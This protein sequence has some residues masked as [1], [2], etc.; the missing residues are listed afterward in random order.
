M[1]TKHPILDGADLKPAAENGLFDRR[2]FFKGGAALATA[3]TGYTIGNSAVAQQLADDPW[4]RGIGNQVK[5]Y[6]T[7]SQYESGVARILSNPNN[8]PRTQHGRTPHHLING[9]FTPNPLHF[10]I[11]HTGNPDIDPSAHKLLIHG[12]V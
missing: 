7:P 6:G 1:T 12:L 11:S 10:V 8:E 2:A 9:T 3:M 5:A 4:S